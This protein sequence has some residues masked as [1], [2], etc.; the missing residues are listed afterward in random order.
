MKD[1]NRSREFLKR[2]RVFCENLCLEAAMGFAIG[3]FSLTCVFES[4]TIAFEPGTC[5]GGL[6]LVC[7]NCRYC[8]HCSNGGTCSVCSRANSSSGKSST[9]GKADQSGNADAN[10]ARDSEKRKSL[11]NAMALN[12]EVERIYNARL[13]QYQS[14]HRA[15]VTAKELREKAEQD[16]R[17]FDAKAAAIQDEKP[18]KP[19]YGTHEWET[20]DGK[21][22]TRAELI[23]T[24]N[25]NVT[26]KKSDGKIVTVPKE[27]L[28]HSSRLIVEKAFTELSTY[29]SQLS[30]W[31]KLDAQRRIAA[32]KFAFLKREPQP[33]IRGRI[34]A[35]I[36]ARNVQVSKRQ[37]IES[38]SLL[39]EEAWKSPLLTDETWKSP[40]GYSI[41]VFVIENPGMQAEVLECYVGNYT[42]PEGKA[43]NSLCIDWINNGESTIRLLRA[44][45]TAYSNLGKIVYQTND[46]I[47]YSASDDEPGIMAGSSYQEPIDE[48]HI[49]WHPD[50]KLPDSEVVKVKVKLVMTNEFSNFSFKN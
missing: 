44:D 45:I 1:N 40:K 4:S 9:S 2:N 7:K 48:G 11:E 23:D 42:N 13:K 39:A 37:L 33:P 35:E 29:K 46:Q 14:R 25:I 31:D 49:F 24:D 22:K 47:I 38:Q 12:L 50:N 18:T 20:R 16:S 36:A 26:L 6:C 5:R 30:E 3:F 21:Y 27:T 10:K 41:K 32:K 19:Y 28:I 15:W 8:G 17:F 43:F 34:I